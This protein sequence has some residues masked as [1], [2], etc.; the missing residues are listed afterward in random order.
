MNA[1]EAA[2]WLLAMLAAYLS[3]SVQTVCNRFAGLCAH[4]RVEWQILGNGTRLVPDPGSTASS[5][6]LLRAVIQASDSLLRAVVKPPKP[7]KQAH[8]SS[9]RQRQTSCQ[10]ALFSPSAKNNT[11]K[12]SHGPTS[13]QEQATTVLQAIKTHNTSPSM[14]ATRLSDSDSLL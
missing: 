5:N 7:P 1:G 9:H 8:R 12:P 14:R 4:Y 10:D 13:R 3:G 11:T 6:S 2:G